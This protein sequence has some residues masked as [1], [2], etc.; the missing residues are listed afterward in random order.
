[1]SLGA[2]SILLVTARVGLAQVPLNNGQNHTG[3]I[4]VA[5]GVDSWSF[6]SNKND[7]ISL[8]LTETV[9]AGGFAPKLELIAPNGARLGTSSGA[10][11]TTINIDA[12]Q[13]GTYTV[14]ASSGDAPR[15]GTGS[16]RLILAR[17]P[18]P[19]VVSPGDEGGALTNGENHVATLVPGDIDLFTFQARGG[20]SVTLSLTKLTDAGNFNP[21]VR[22]RGPTAL[23][24]AQSIEADVVQVEFNIIRE[25]TYTVVVA[26]LDGQRGGSGTYMLTMAKSSEPFVVPT[27]DEGGAIINGDNHLGTTHRGDLDSWSFQANANAAVSLSVSRLSD[28]GSFR[29]RILLRAPSGEQLFSA[30]SPLSPAVVQ[31]H[32]LR[33]PQTGTYTVVIGSGDEHHVGAGT[34]RLTLARSPG[35]FVVAPGDDGG[36]L[37][38]G[39]PQFGAIDAGDLD[40]WSFDVVAGERLS[41][42]MRILT[43]MGTF[44]SAIRLRR[45]DGREIESKVSFNPPQIVM[46]PLQTGTYTVVISSGDI[47]RLG[48]GTYE[49]SATR[50]P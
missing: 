17:L 31:S 27:G 21:W 22:V 18:G 30:S 3:T 46:H 50:S 36:L 49:I 5:G 34:Y 47:Q 7:A 24:N 9:D 33:V 15:V 26:S 10:V 38:N 2:L 28:A 13:T 1:V 39:V 32:V 8:S 48:T 42:S 25:G 37:G 4:A 19:F 6:Q 40:Q 43:N 44:V 14:L 35:G 41:I 11:V 45:P 29:P 16:Y 12:P 23:L 20:E